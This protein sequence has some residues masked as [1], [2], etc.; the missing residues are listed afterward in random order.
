MPSDMALPTLS[1]VARAAGVS[2]ATVSRCLNE[3]TRVQQKTRDK[4]LAAVEALGYAP[5][6][7]ARAMAA[8]RTM[9]IGAIVPTLEN[10]IFAKGL[11]AFQE[12]VHAQG[13]TL[14]VASSA[15]DPKVEA[16]HVRAL[17]ARGADGLLLIGHDRDPTIGAY[18]AQR[19]VPSV[20]AWAY[21][22]QAEMACVGFDNRA[23]MRAMAG[24]AIAM[25]HRDIAM[26]AGLTRGN[27]RAAE[28]V[29]G[30]RDAMQAAGLKAEALHLVETRY[31][32]AAGGAALVQ[33]LQNPPRPSLVL[34]GND[35]LAVG[36]MQQA[37]EM[38]LRVPDDLS[39]TGFDDIELA[40][41]VTPALTTMHVPHAQM[42]HRA[43]Q[44]LIALME[45]HGDAR[46]VRLD[47]TLKM[48]ASLSP[49]RSA[50]S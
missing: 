30:V 29:A 26:I 36:A 15:Y 50:T 27:D 28:R 2:T 3:P 46:S 43:A 42:G 48:R 49:P 12:G 40:R 31:D 18:L 5:N 10:S 21:R 6:F 4:V 14:L 47:A 20:A 37:H 19:R 33:I 41:I 44:T 24:A 35:V 34:C 7:G 8:K 17:V 32:I 23:A 16:E 25:G 38:G 45:G 11:Q 22:A 39:I 1:D 13:Y 9:T